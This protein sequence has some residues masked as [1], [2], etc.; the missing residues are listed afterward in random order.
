MDY[1]ISVQLKG[2][3]YIGVISIICLFID[4][5]AFFFLYFNNSRKQ[6]K[7][8]IPNIIIVGCFFQS[9]ISYCCLIS[10]NINDFFNNN[11][12][13]KILTFNF[14]IKGEEKFSIFFGLTE[15]LTNFMKFFNFA[16]F[17]FS[18]IGSYMTE[19][20]YCFESIY[21]FQNPVSNTKTRKIIYALLG[22]IITLI[23]GFYS[24]GNAFDPE[25][26]N[27]NVNRSYIFD[28]L[29]NDFDS[30]LRNCF[31]FDLEFASNFSNCVKIIFGND[32]RYFG[33]IIKCINFPLLILTIIYIFIDL[34]SVVAILNS[35]KVQS[36]LFIYEKA[37]FRTRHIFYS[38]FGIIL[39]LAI[40]IPLYF[41]IINENSYI[42][43]EIKKYNIL[44]SFITI[45]L[46]IF[47]VS[48]SI[49][50]FLEID[51]P[52][53]ISFSGNLSKEGY[54]GKAIQQ[55][56]KLIEDNEEK[57]NL[58]LK[59]QGKE[60]EILRV[61][62]VFED[63]PFDEKNIKEYL[64]HKKSKGDIKNKL[65]LSAQIACDFL[66]ESV[67]YIV[68]CI[69]YIGK[70]IKEIPMIGDESYTMCNEHILKTDSII[71]KKK[72]NYKEIINNDLLIEKR[73]NRLLSLI[74]DDIK[75]ADEEEKNLI[76]T[77]DI[78]KPEID[79]FIKPKENDSK[80]NEWITH[81]I[82]LKQVK[83]GNFF[84]NFFSRNIKII[85]YAPEIFRNILRLDKI[86]KKQLISSFNVIDNILKLSNFK[87]SEGKSG[88]IFF[89]THDKKFIIKTISEGELKSM[90]DNLI[91]K[92]YT[93]FSTNVFS[94]LTRIYGLYTL[95]LGMSKV[96]V[97]VMENIFPF[98]KKS[99]VCKY[100]L[101]GSSAGRKTK[102]IFDKKGV[103][104]KDNDYIELS[105]KDSKFKINLTD[106]SKDYIN[107]VMSGDLN[108]LEEARLMDYSL[109]VCIAKKKLI[110]KEKDKI[111]IKDRIFESTDKRYVY[112]LGIIDYLTEFGTKKKL[113][114]RYKRF[115]NKKK[116]AMSSINPSKYRQRFI[117]F[118]KKYSVL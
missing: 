11:P 107:Q 2:K 5:I 6:N 65:S 24:I 54:N 86:D 44:C 47:G 42:N 95:I 80:E 103:T 22:S 4:L 18:L 71:R 61:S 57:E 114:Y 30:I 117:L 25:K 46:N 96:H 19:I 85:E 64:S 79:D 31:S 115:F 16:I 84:T 82:S 27:K 10:T 53:H 94:N 17:I 8:L 100:D 48:N 23:V 38:F 87:G 45:G 14:I 83:L 34:I 63:K 43:D 20:F 52:N 1:N 75:V 88:S 109:F 78:N 70:N 74:S 68:S 92:Y 67:Y 66:S 58:K 62:K 37:I 101:K 81:S 102:K 15:Y 36:K 106:E 116:Y 97:V 98:D 13:P 69:T 55:F 28:D 32:D 105:N 7:S 113:E 39:T 21:L 56:L 99:L 3:I 9:I 111:I 72:N 12:L 35:I 41:I 89:E 77:D 51:I 33:I 29:D 40:V 112:I 50:R 108:I 26:I 91:Q 90:M 104:L 118:L 110:E 93:L 73:D 76:N 49:F 59:L 60:E